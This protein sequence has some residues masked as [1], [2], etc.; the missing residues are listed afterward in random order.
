M[1]VHRGHC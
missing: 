1:F